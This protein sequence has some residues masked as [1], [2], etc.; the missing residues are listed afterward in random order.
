MKSSEEVFDI[1]WTY[2]VIKTGRHRLYRY[3]VIRRGV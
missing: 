1:E 3:A 2:I